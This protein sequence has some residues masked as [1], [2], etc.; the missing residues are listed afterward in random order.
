MVCTSE[1]GEKNSP[2]LLCL[3]NGKLGEEVLV[4]ATEDVAGGLPNP[5]A[6]EE[7][8]QVFKDLRLED[9]VVLRQHSLKRFKLCFNSHHRL[10]NEAWQVTTAGGGLLH[11]PI[12][13][14][15]LRE[16]QR[17]AP[18]I[19]GGQHLSLGHLAGRLLYLDLG[20]SR[21]KAIG[22]VTEENYPQDRHEVV[23]GS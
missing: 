10:S 3:L 7:A 8:H 4:N 20:R 19:V 11:D 12:V 15:I 1:D 9:P 17:T 18:E 13:A 2:L 6:V 16:P 21:F 5:L 23:A 22:C 14:S